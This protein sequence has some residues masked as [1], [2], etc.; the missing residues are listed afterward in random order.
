MRGIQAQ[1]T[2]LPNRSTLFPAALA[3]AAIFSSLAVAQRPGT[4]S[5]FQFQKA[6]GRLS[7]TDEFTADPV[8]SRI[9]FDKPAGQIPIKHSWSSTSPNDIGFDGAIT[10]RFPN[11]TPTGT[12]QTRGGFTNFEPGHFLVR[13][14]RRLRFTL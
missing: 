8:V 4:P 3:L 5:R 14:K 11:L 10:F 9:S 1:K 7:T 2:G 13:P 12:V 6:D